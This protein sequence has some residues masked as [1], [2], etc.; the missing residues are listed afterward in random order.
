M[1][2]TAPVPN[3]PPLPGMCPSIAVLAGGGDGGGSGGNGAGNGN[4]DG[5]GNG[6][7]NGDAAN[8]DGTNSGTC[9]NGANGSC[10]NCSSGTSAG[11]PINVATGEVFTIPKTD[12]FLPGFFNV[13]LD[14]SSARATVSTT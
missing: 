14:R 9:G 8:G 3:L 11:D 2:R 1:A 12:L 10:T 7:G 4:G 5:P 6:D 13:Q